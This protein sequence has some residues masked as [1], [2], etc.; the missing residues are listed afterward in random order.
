MASDQIEKKLNKMNSVYFFPEGF[1]TDGSRLLPFKSNFFQTAVNC[2]IDILP[3][4]IGYTSDGK[5][6][7]APSYAADI[8]LAQSMLALIKVK[9]LTAH[10]SV[11]Q[12]VSSKKNRKFIANEAHQKIYK[13]LSTI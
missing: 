9:N 3:L 12:V 6:S 8:S 4:S 5:F 10:I 11:L 7:S 1:A 2:N 13:A